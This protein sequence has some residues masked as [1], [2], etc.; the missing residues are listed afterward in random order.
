MGMT[1]SYSY[2]ANGV[3]RKMTCDLL[4]RYNSNFLELVIVYIP[5]I[6]VEEFNY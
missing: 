3:K 5:C 4:V 6:N 2:W 1:N